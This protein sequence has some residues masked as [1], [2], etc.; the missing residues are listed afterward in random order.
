MRQ[1]FETTNAHKEGLTGVCFASINGAPHVL[2][3]GSDGNVC[4]RSTRRLD[5]VVS[6]FAIGKALYSIAAHKDGAQFVTTDE[7]HYVKVRVSVNG[8]PA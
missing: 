1:E 6:S 8:L 4:L 3:C 2:S 5:E 7:D